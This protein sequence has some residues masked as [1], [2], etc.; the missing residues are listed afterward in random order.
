MN[1]ELFKFM[2]T[3]YEEN[4]TLVLMS[5]SASIF[6]SGLDSIVIPRTLANVFNS[7]A[8]ADTETIEDGGEKVKKRGPHHVLTSDG[9]GFTMQ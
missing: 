9:S 8:D 2:Y 4:K 6:K 1:L 3:F 5:I 7:L